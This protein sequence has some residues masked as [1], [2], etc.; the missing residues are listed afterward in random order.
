MLLKP[1]RL[2]HLPTLLNGV[3]FILPER[4]VP[5]HDNVLYILKSSQF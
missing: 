5:L 1:H 2:I 4:K 3:F